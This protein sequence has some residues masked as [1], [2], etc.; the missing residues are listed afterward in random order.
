MEQ[1]T[2]FLNNKGDCIKFSYDGINV[3]F[4]GPYSLEYIAE[5][6]EWD[7]G[8]LVVMAKYL[9]QNSLVEDY[10]D[11]VPILNNLYINA[12]EFLKPIKEVKL[13]YACSRK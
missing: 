4:K 2:A 3:R 13:D 9:H 10:I 1:K 11:M 6:K 12:D 5:I 8:Y 7:R